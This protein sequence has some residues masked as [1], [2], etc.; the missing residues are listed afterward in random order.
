VGFGISRADV[1]H[2]AAFLA[3]RLKYEI[4]LSQNG[5]TLAERVL[6]EDDIQAAKAVSSLPRAA[7][8]AHVSSK[9]K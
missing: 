3:N 8:L 5:V 2:E 6:L 9:I 7:E 1:E 4:V